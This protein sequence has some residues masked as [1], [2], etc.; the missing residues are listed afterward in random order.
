MERRQNRCD[1]QKL[2]GRTEPSPD[3]MGCKKRERERDDRLETAVEKE[4]RR[5]KTVTHTHL[6]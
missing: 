1:G 6:F 5:N 2:L 4:T 3:T